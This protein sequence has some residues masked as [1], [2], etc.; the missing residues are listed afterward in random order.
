MHIA[1]RY[2]ATINNGGGA[3]SIGQVTDGITIE[4]FAN[5]R[6]ITGDNEGLTPQDAV[7]QGLEVFVEFTLMEFNKAGVFDLFWPYS[8]TLGAQGTVGRLDVAS[9]LTGSLVM[10]AVAGTTAAD[11]AT[12]GGAEA[13]AGL[14]NTLTFPRVM[15]AEGFPVRMLHGPLDYRSIPLRLRVYPNASSI[16]YA[17]S[18]V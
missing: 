7:F 9:S 8:S 18:T 12:G 5:K 6:L 17:W 2:T 16:F 14:G 15:L 4:H 13:A 11:T 3:L 1:G 10:T